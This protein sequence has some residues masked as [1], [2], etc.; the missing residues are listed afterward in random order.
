MSL[1]LIL[2]TIGIFH[3]DWTAGDADKQRQPLSKFIEAG[4][5]SPT[6]IYM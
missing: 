2:F 4:V 1:F 5:D 6:V 3:H